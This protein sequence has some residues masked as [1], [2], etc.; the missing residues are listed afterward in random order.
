MNSIS[1][2][3]EK[4]LYKGLLVNPNL[5]LA[6]FKFHSECTEAGINRHCTLPNNL[7]MTATDNFWLPYIQSHSRMPRKASLAKK[8]YLYS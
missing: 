3:L 7:H 5:L 4:E 1:D 2:N 6:N 8:L